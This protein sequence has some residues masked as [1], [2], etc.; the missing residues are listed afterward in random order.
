MK[1][2]LNAILI[3]LLIISPV[4]AVDLS[5]FPNMFLDDVRIVV[6]RSANAEDVI[7]AIDVIVA[8]QQRVGKS[9]RL[10][11]AVLD[12]E[13][14][15]LADKNTIVVGGPC[16]NSMAAQLLN[17]PQNCL[18]GF[19]LGKGTIKLYEFNNGNVALLAAGATALDTR[20]VTTV[21]ANY[22]DYALKGAE[23]TITGFT[24]ADIQV[25]SK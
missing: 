12:T 7:G 19:E 6:G 8:L 13:V 17:Y 10:G 11:G 1:Y 16:I 4:F 2:I 24:I 25:N 21:L 22:P 15:N 20:R 3:S 9:Y 18:E 23:I 14:E 5:D